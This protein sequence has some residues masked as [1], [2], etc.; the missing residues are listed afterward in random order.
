MT[1][2]VNLLVLSVDF[3]AGAADANGWLSVSVASAVAE[4][5][6]DAVIKK[7]LTKRFMITSHMIAE[8][9][10][11]G[12]NCCTINKVGAKYNSELLIYQQLC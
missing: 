4:C 5:K 1:T 6:R 3:T 8:R 2:G 11:C 7:G 10:A 12:L 9:P